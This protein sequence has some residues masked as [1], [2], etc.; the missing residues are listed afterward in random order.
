[1]EPLHAIDRPDR[2]WGPDELTVLPGLQRTDREELGR[3]HATGQASAAANCLSAAQAASLFETDCAK[4]WRTYQE[5]AIYAASRI[6]QLRKSS[7]AASQLLKPVKST[8]Y[9]MSTQTSR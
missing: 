9:V 2:R 3:G 4:P 5:Q 1:M 7:S 8:T 6:N